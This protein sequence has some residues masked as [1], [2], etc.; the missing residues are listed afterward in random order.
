M[1]KVSVVIITFNEERNIGPT[2][3]AAREVADEIIVMDSGSTDN[4]KEICA[5]MGARFIYQSWLGFGTQRNL[6]VSSASH[7]HILVLDADEVLDEVLI[8]NIQQLKKS[9]LGEAVYAV[10]RRNYYY[11]KFIRFGIAGVEIK[12]RLYHREFARWNTR[13]VH[14]DLEFAPALKAHTLQGY[15]LHYT[16]RTIAEHMEK[17]NRYSTLS[18]QEYYNNGRKEPGFVKLVL[19]PCFT[20]LNA[21]IFKVGFLD[22]WHGWML[23]KFHALEVLQKY[24]KLK[25][26]YRER[27]EKA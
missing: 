26:L 4:T 17:M 2:L 25:M 11:G 8:K 7:D 15:L 13:L 18:A 22:G 5:S 1:N 24:A 10:Q 27:R 23:S 9:G 12:P 19:N 14:E 3:Q 6:A 20:F 21:Y 16:Y